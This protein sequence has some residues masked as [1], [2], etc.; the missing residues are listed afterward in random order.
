VPRFLEIYNEE[1]Q[2]LLVDPPK[3]DKKKPGVAKIKKTT[4]LM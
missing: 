1:L 4:D 2:D 3:D